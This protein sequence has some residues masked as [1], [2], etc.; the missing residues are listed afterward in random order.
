MFT[1][2]D[3]DMPS[4]AVKPVFEACPARPK[5]FANLANG[6]HMEPEHEGRNN[7]FDAHFLACHVADY[8]PSCDLIYKDTPSNLCKQED[9]VDCDVIPAS[10]SMGLK[11]DDISARRC[12]GHEM[13]ATL[14][15][16]ISKVSKPQRSC[17]Q[18]NA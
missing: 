16:D 17:S 12:Y 9:Y 14:K 1:A 7:P 13:Q 4:H 18:H 2:C 10:K 15:K 3:G 8:Q 5:V 6:S 11:A